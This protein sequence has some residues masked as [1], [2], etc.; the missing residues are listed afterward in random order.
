M[1]PVTRG[2][3]REAAKVRNDIRLRQRLSERATNNDSPP[4]TGLPNDGGRGGRER[5]RE[6]VAPKAAHAT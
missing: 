2:P 4:I 3:E 5:E 6:R 1:D